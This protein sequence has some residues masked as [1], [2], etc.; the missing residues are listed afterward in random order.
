[1]SA[2]R[3]GILGAGAFGTALADRVARQG[4][5]VVLWSDD[6]A[7][8]EE[9]RERRTNERRLPG[10]TVHENVRLTG[11]LAVAAREARVLLLAVPSRRIGGLAAALGDVV[12]GA[13]ILL[14]ASGALVGPDGMERVSDLFRR[15]TCVRRI[16]A[17]AGPALAR[18][19]ADGRPCAVV[20][21]SPFDEVCAVG[22]E[23]LGAAGSLRAYVSRDLIGVELASALSGA[24]T[25]AVGI[26]DG[27]NL[28]AGP[29]AVLVTRAVAEMA[30]LGVAAG[31]RERTFV[32]LAGLGNLL[33]RSSSTSA[34]HS[35]DYRLG[36]VL[37]AG[38]APTRA[39]TEG[40]RVL[41]AA[42]ALARR[43]GVRT[44]ILDAVHSAVNS[45]VSVKEAAARL[46]ESE[47]DE[48]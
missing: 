45:G 26:A 25:V 32:G 33:V 22:R 40:S 31:A 12:S 48:E 39:E 34:G 37:A 46:L 9:L 47:A 38:N 18:D 6:V 16:G 28:G 13:H 1:M 2:D 35:D 30:R 21:A 27:L 15:E 7:V 29:R 11:D 10:V 4:R 17:V 44:P 41:G 8:V 42:V 19:L 36:R 23:L 5:E 14:H 43:L 3:L 24:M 20:V